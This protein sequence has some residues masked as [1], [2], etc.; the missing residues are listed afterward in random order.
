MKKYE[1]YNKSNETYRKKIHAM[2]GFQ[3]YNLEPCHAR[4]SKIFYLV[5]FRIFEPYQSSKNN[6]KQLKSIEKQWNMMKNGK[7]NEQLWKDR[8]KQWKIM[9]NKTKT[10]NHDEKE[11]K[12]QWNNMKNREE[13][14]KIYEK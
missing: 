8:Q 7:N 1:K 11:R 13:T 5:R 3:V 6:I 9:K 4:V 14:M 12:K 10:M 2:E